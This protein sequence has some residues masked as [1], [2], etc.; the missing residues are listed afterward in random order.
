MLSSQHV[1][2]ASSAAV[3]T[4]CGRAAC[5]CVDKGPHF[6]GHARCCQVM[7]AYHAGSCWG[8]KWPTNLTRSI[9]TLQLTQMLAQLGTLLAGCWFCGV[10]YHVSFWPS[11]AMF[12]TY[13]CMFASSCRDGD[14]TKRMTVK[15][16][17]NAHPAAG[18]LHPPL[19]GCTLVLCRSF[20]ALSAGQRL[21]QCGKAFTGTW[22]YK[23]M[24][25][26][27]CGIATMHQGAHT[28]V[29]TAQNSQVH[30]KRAALLQPPACCV[31]AKGEVE[32]QPWQSFVT[33]DGFDYDI[34]E[35]ARRH[36]GGGVIKH[37]MGLDATAAFKEFHR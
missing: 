24:H 36:P 13:T 34:T 21:H 29:C 35:F 16:D 10:N 7:Y 28:S 9:T 8:I 32:T 31:A 25:L 2:D 18:N 3:H 23:D 11:A 4:S 33:I 6:M 17:T 15:Q 1:V 26:H 5:G 30:H 22:A 27:T 20:S 37:Y 12:V 19:A 14:I